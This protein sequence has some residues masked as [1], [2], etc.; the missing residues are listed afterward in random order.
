[1]QPAAPWGACQAAEPR[2]YLS[3]DYIDTVIQQAFYKFNQ[4][5]A[6]N[7]AVYMQQQAIADAKATAANLKQ[8]AAG[9][10]NERYVLFRVGELENQTWLEEQDLVQKKREKNQKIINALIEQFNVEVGKRRPD[11]TILE[12]MYG[13]MASVDAAKAEEIYR[14]LTDRMRNVSREIIFSI[15]K[16][17]VT[18]DLFAAQREL[19]YCRR[20]RGYLTLPKDRMASAEAIITARI[21]GENI[22][23]LMRENL[24][25]TQKYLNAGRYMHARSALQNVQFSCDQN[26]MP[27]GEHELCVEKAASLQRRIDAREDSLVTIN[28]ALLQNRGIDAAIDYMQFTLRNAEVLPEKVAKVDAAIRAVPIVR[29][30]AGDAKIR[31]ELDELATGGTDNGLSMDAVQQAVQKRAQA[32]ADSLRLI[33]EKRAREEARKNRGAVAKAER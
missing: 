27:R 18:S 22:V 29:E 24:D 10:P 28:L 8:M 15:E 21:D 12:A 3:K 31:K 25:S 23:K 5:A 26:V 17:L 33:E 20:N 6:V 14:S 11:F 19:D 9:D 7:G 2:P 4:A 1:M 32:R 16:S 30:S 13:Q